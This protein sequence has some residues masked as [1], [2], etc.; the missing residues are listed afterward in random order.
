M[1]E[2]ESKAKEPATAAEETTT[3]QQSESTQ[4]VAAPEALDTAS[5][6]ASGEN[7]E[8]P[9][10]AP[11]DGEGC[12][13]VTVV[14]IARDEKHGKLMA[15]SVKKNLIGVDADIQLVNGDNLCDTD[16]ETLLN[17]MPHIRT[18]RL[19]LMTEGMV[20]LNPVMLGDVSVVKAVKAGQYFDFFTQTPVL[21][22]KSA[23]QGLIDALVKADRLHSDVVNDYFPGILPTNF[24][25]VLIGDWT[26][27]PWLLPVISKD[28]NIAIVKKYAEWKKFM[29]VGP[30]SWSEG[31]VK[32][33]EERFPE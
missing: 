12:E 22:H 2:D 31:M 11:S 3:E 14:I 5:G 1:K 8:Q 6:S 29:H 30:G 25:P 17:H 27:D 7:V 32:F 19:I 16:I 10:G 18:E 28:P 33:L 21:M 20:I 26:K 4:S 15:R 23:L 9:A 13:S 24:T